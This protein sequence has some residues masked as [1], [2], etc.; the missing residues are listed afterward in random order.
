MSTPSSDSLS[1]MSSIV[2]GGRKGFLPSNIPFADNP[3]GV[4]A[5]L[6]LGV[7]IL[8]WLVS[9]YRKPVIADD[10]TD[11]G[12]VPVERGSKVDVV[13]SSVRYALRRLLLDEHELEQYETINRVHEIHV[14]DGALITHQGS[15]HCQSVQFEIRA[16]RTLIA[17][18]GPGK[19][20]YRHT[21]MRSTNLRI[22][23]GV[24][25][26]KTYYVKV[27][28]DRGAHAFCDRCGC[29][30]L[31]APSRNSL[32]ILINTNCIDE[33]IRKIKVVDTKSSL[34]TGSSLESQW[35]EQLTTISELSHD[36]HFS[37]KPTPFHVDSSLSIDGES[38][39][40]DYKLYDEVDRLDPFRQKSYLRSPRTLTTVDSFTSHA[41]DTNSL[42]ALR[43]PTGHYADSASV[44]TDDAF[45]VTHSEFARSGISPTKSLAQMK[46]YMKKH[47]T[48]PPRE[49]PQVQG[50]S[51]ETPNRR[52][53]ASNAGEVVA[54]LLNFS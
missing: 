44:M 7:G 29:H 40:T 33:G 38:I 3:L 8:R 28:D 24:K 48:P 49:S 10:D 16:P 50:S 46:K 36:M 41:I 43:I 11:D 21:E 17:K 23:R 51:R 22:M 9:S 14:V 30:L 1:S 12:D 6:S 42:P 39:S 15:C 26:L 32:R 45:S 4:A 5:T 54:S 37:I 25:H 20:N 53:M 2:L 27:K 35:D 34:A 18:E 13:L 47:A 31:Y 52:Q 19:I